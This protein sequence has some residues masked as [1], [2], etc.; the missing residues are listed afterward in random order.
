MNQ[1]TELYDEINEI[2]RFAEGDE[3]ENEN[4]VMEYF[5]PENMK[6]MFGECPISPEKLGEYAF[7][8]IANQW[9]M[10]SK[11]I[12]QLIEKHNLVRIVSA[13]E[14][15]FPK[16]TTFLNEKYR[17]SYFADDCYRFSYWKPTR[18]S[19]LLRNY[20][21]FT[22]KPQK[23]RVYVENRVPHEIHE[24]MN[25]EDILQ[26]INDL[27]ALLKEIHEKNTNFYASLTN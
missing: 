10:K 20:V 7:Y 15:H 24:Y 23:D 18:K 13:I 6:E 27:P 12:Y 21:F 25:Y 14:K 16:Y 17:I 5:T 19:L 1:T 22:E 4:A 9:H 26:L 3:F 8:V 2:T 11:L